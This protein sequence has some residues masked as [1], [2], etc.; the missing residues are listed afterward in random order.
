MSPIM[1][2]AKSKCCCFCIK[3]G[4]EEAVVMEL[5][6]EVHYHEV[7]VFKS[8]LGFRRHIS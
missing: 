8:S 5:R 4:K 3:K 6:E 7:G 2:S 1:Q